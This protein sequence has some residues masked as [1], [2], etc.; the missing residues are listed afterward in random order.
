MKRP[1]VLAP[2]G[3]PEALEA[4][5]RAGADAV[6][7]GGRLLNARRG[8]ANFDDAQ[9]T[10]AVAF[11]HARGVKVYLTLNT[12]VADAE[13]RVAA[14][15]VEQACSLGVDA[16]IL[17]DIGLARLCRAVCPEMR[18]HASTQLSIHSLAG[19]EEAAEMGFRRVVLA[20]ELSLKEIEEIATNS[21]CELEIFVHGALCMSV[22][23]QCYLSAMLGGRSGNR[24]LCAQP[25]RLP[26]TGGDAGHCLSL[27]DLSLVEQLPRLAQ[28]GAASFKIEGRMKRPEYV[29]AATTACRKAANGEPVGER[30]LQALR[31]VFSR[32]GFTDGYFSGARG[33][34]MFGARQYEDVV[35][36]QGVFGELH[37]LYK[38]EYPRVPVHMRLTLQAGA[39]VQLSVRD[40]DGFEAQAEGDVPEPARVKAVDEALAKE[41]LEKTGGTPFLAREI[42][43]DIGPGLSIAVSALNRLRREAL[44]Q[45]TALRA[46]PRPV[47]FDAEAVG[48]MLEPVQRAQ[49]QES[50]GAMELLI[51]LR[52]LNQLG[53]GMREAALIFAPVE[54]LARDPARTAAL[55]RD[56]FALAAELPRV[57]FGLERQQVLSGALASLRDAGIAVALCGNLGTVRLARR[58]GLRVFGDFGLN[59]TNRLAFA[60][61]RAHGVRDCVLSFEQTLASLKETASAA[62]GHAALLGYGRLPLMLTRLCP[63]RDGAAL[64]CPHAAQKRPC[65]GALTDRRAERFPIV[66]RQGLYSELLNTRPLWMPDRKAELAA[67]GTAYAML[68]FTTETAAEADAALRAWQ[69]GGPPPELF[70]RGLYYRGIL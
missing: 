56:G 36:A 5:V 12:L 21:P 68:S 34:E 70:T 54:E 8:A 30:E 11:C 6:Y 55:L 16:L 2:A 64:P 69:A 50:G 29:A 10:G 4:A 17:Q 49:S 38:E 62:P 28:A 31:S 47:S 9:L 66:C 43:T 27:R 33:H 46:A 45:L 59:V 7:L 18:L 32:S 26:F 24:G 23:G 20:R 60:E 1:E 57:V 40:A 19:V 25:C 22:S 65:P 61:A 42:E 14:G 51:R 41:K 48:A 44:D 37:A 63:L 13:L 35:A 53:D 67:T 15:A 52:G 3:S 58:A 39:P